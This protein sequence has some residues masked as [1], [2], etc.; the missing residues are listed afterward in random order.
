[1][2]LI[3]AR[4]WASWA[5]VFVAT[6]L[7][8]CGAGHEEPKALPPTGSEYLAGTET[9]SSS[10]EACVLSVRAISASIA[11][12]T[13]TLVDMPSTQFLMV[14]I[15]STDGA[16]EVTCSGSNHQMRID[17]FRPYA[18]RRRSGRGG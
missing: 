2:T 3:R 13:T 4:L 6:T 12:T 17:T 9:R 15:E 14:R 1:M 16:S 5:M 11:N 7:A 10:Y 8:G 18:H